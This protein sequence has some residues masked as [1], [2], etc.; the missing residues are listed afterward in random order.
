MSTTGTGQITSKHSPTISG[1]HLVSQ[2]PS[3][4]EEYFRR[5]LSADHARTPARS[6]EW[7]F[8]FELLGSTGA[9]ITWT[10]NVGGS[11]IRAAL[12]GSTVAVHLYNSAPTSYRIGRRTL[13]SD[14][15]RAVVLFPGHE[16]TARVRAGSASGFH[17]R[18]DR[19][20]EE[21][22]SR[23]AR[24]IRAFSGRSTEMPLPQLPPLDLRSDADA[25]LVG[26]DETTRLE[27]FEA[28]ESR[29]TA[30]LARALLAQEGTLAASPA[31]IKVAED[32]E[33]WIC[34]HLA[35]HITLDRLSAVAGVSG[36]WLQKSMLQRWGLTPLELAASRRLSAVRARL[37]AASA[38]SGVTRIAMECGFTHLGR[39]SA[40]YRS[41]FGELPSDT[42]ARAESRCVG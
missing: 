8:E 23:R 31:A 19:L 4:V 22:E 24:R 27:R 12:P 11:T 33:R 21:I 28:W 18:L 10:R 38:G 14:S 9:G 26:S 41:T 42:L 30:V 1:L 39:F 25:I 32:M 7:R 3:Q 13:T 16:Y 17:V 37:I 15:G 6:G 20:I 36:R 29:T 5:S 2:D 34:A 35:E 40:L